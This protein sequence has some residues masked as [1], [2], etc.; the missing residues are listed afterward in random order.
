MKK[1]EF[2]TRAQ[3][4]LVASAMKLLGRQGR[5]TITFKAPT[6]AG[7]TVMM[8]NMLAQLTRESAGLHNLAILWVAP[9]KLHEQ[10]HARLLSV[11]NQTKSLEC[12][13]PE[14]LDGTEIPEKSVLFLNWASIDSDK[15]VLRRDNETGRNLDAFVN[16]A[17]AAGRKVVLVVDES[18][19]HLDSGPQAQIVIDHIIKPD[20]VIEVSATPRNKTPDMAV[21]VLREDVVAAG[22]IREKI[23]V[24]PG[25]EDVVADGNELVVNYEGTAESLLDLAL[26]KQAEL[27]RLYQEEGSPVV[28]LILVQLPSKNVDS[29]ALARFERHLGATHGMFRGDGLEVW[30]AEDQTSGL[31]E[32]ASF[33]S[34]AKVL[35]FKQG[36]ATGWDCPRAQILVGLREMKSDTFKTQV[37]GRIIRQPEHKHYANEVLNYGYAFT[38]Y[39]RLK[40]DAEAATWMGKVMVRAQTG[41]S[42]PFLNWANKHVDRRHHLNRIALT[43]MLSHKHL[44]AAVR[45]QSSVTVKMLAGVEIEDIDKAYEEE[46]LR[47]VVLDLEGLQEKLNQHKA[48]LVAELADQG[49]G[50]KYVEEALRAAASEVAQ[51]QEERVLLE[52]ILHSSNW[53]HFESMVRSGIEDFKASQVKIARSLEPRDGWAAPSERFLDLANPMDF[54]RC[55]YKPVLDGQFA[56]SNVEE[57]FAKWLDGQENVEVWLK[58]GDSGSEHF[59]IRYELDEPHL[60]FPDFLVRLKGGKVY[61]LDTKGAGSSDL[62]TGNMT[63]THAKARALYAYT[64]S[65]RAAGHSVIGGLVVRKHGAW[66]LHEGENYPGTT[67]V[68]TDLGWRRLAVL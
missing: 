19:L 44:V 38:N 47:D 37:L 46:G 48:E 25:K 26:N 3:D 9:N 54:T 62:S 11:Y 14:E 58:N 41:F 59:A 57:P 15:L 56:K 29:E 13:F 30:L 17:R 52:T 12:V 23:I 31:S 35:F 65:L 10:S 53:P 68:S 42:L 1:L 36:I 2:Q 5:S 4:D 55:L 49:G 50:R 21:T 64:E 33:G 16:H 45:H 67:S 39:D 60:F 51:S 28:P 20:L 22:L 66:W 32:I 61:L 8:A 18:H 40:L 63:D 34:N 7:K 24:N 27:T 43:A 6:G